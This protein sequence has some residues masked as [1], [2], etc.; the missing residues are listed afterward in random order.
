MSLHCSSMLYS[1]FHS[2]QDC[3]SATKD[4]EVNSLSTH[5]VF[6]SPGRIQRLP[7]WFDYR[8][9]ISSDFDFAIWASI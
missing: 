7:R 3:E 5:Y 2:D 4:S 8:Q 6:P 9:D 1:R